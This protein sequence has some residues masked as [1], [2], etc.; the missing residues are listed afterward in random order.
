MVALSRFYERS[1]QRRRTT[2][3]NV[4][5]LSQ[6]RRRAHFSYRDD[7]P[8]AVLGSQFREEKPEKMI[9]LSQGRDRR[10][11]AS[12]GESLLYSDAWGKSLDVIDVRPLKLFDERAGVR[13]HAVQ[14]APLSFGEKNVESQTRFSGSAEARNNHHL[15]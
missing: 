13:R 5:N 2:A 14:E 7:A 11:S 8:W 12:L 6:H 4:R 15:L 9:D 10:F 3:Q 1:G